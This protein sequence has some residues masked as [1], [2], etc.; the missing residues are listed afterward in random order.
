[1][2]W[3]AFMKAIFSCLNLKVDDGCLAYSMREVFNKTEHDLKDT[4]I[5]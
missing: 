3:V 2:V 4:V 5:A 1:M